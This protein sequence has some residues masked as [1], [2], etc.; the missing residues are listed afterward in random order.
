MAPAKLSAGACTRFGK[1]AWRFN[2]QSPSALHEHPADDNLAKVPHDVIENWSPAGPVVGVRAGGHR[3]SVEN[4]TTLT[5][6]LLGG[7]A[8]AAGAYTTFI[9]RLGLEWE[10]VTRLSALRAG[11]YLHPAQIEGSTPR[12]H[13]TTGFEL[14]AVRLFGADWSLSASMN[15]APRAVHLQPRRRLLALA[16][17]SL[18]RAE[19][20]SSSP[21]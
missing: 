12:P 15:L 17:G 20:L 3:L 4:A 1:D 5:P 19:G 6:F 11:T 10:V 13:F 14:R 8:P 7:E 16:A 9:P 18:R 2:R 21:R